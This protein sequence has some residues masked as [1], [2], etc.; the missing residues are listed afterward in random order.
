MPRVRFNP[1]LMAPVLVLLALWSTISYRSQVPSRTDWSAAADHV[2]AQLR[3][4]DG[5]AWAPYWAGEGRLSLHGLP[6]FQ[7]PDVG[8]ADLARYDRVWLLSAFGVDGDDVLDRI[9]SVVHEVASSREF[10]AVTVTELIVRGERVVGDVYGQLESAEVSLVSKGATRACDFWDG[11]GWHCRLKSSADRTR[12]CLGGSTATKLAKHR[13]FGRR[14]RS[15]RKGA[16]K[17]AGGDPRCGLDRWLNVSRDVRVIGDFPRRCIWF[18]PHGG[19]TLRMTWAAAPPGDVV[20]LEH[21]FADKVISDHT[22]GEPRTQPATLRVYRGER[23]LGTRT[24]DPVKGWRSWRVDDQGEGPLRIEVDT[25]ST[26]DAHLCI[27]PTI[28]RA[29]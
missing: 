2:R 23:L 10:G 15:V 28:R 26:V 20:A 11:R 8:Q 12:A 14:G 6:V 21:G 19:K 27:D 4:G 7:L 24:V 13:R 1:W 9:P 22:R 18:H 16:D 3:D 25:V 5:V 29:R 17:V